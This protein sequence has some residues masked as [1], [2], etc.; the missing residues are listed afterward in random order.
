MSLLLKGSTY[1]R[2]AISF[3]YKLIEQNCVDT[4]FKLLKSL[5]KNPARQPE[6]EKT[7]GGQF[8]IRKLVTSDV[9]SYH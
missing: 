9:V 2:D 4:A 3:I 8:F 5:I 7:D 6:N 1:N